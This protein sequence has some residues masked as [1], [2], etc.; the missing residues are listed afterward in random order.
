M[1]TRWLLCLLLGG[2]AYGQAPA[3][4]MSHPHPMPAQN[5][6]ADA[7]AKA[8]AAKISPGEPVITVKG[9][10]ADPAKK[11][12]T[13]ETVVTREQFERLADA[14]QPNMA[15]PIKLR[16][17]NGYSR[18]I[19]LS[20][21]AEK[22]GLD[23][24][25][26]FEA[27]MNFARM[28]ILSQQLTSSLQEESQKVS[29][30]DIEK[31]YND[32]IDTYQEATLQRLYVPH[33]KQVTPPKAAPGVKKDKEAEE[34]E[35]QARIKAGEE[36]MEKTADALRARAAKGESFDALE[37]EAYLAAGLKGNPPSTKM[38]KIRPTSLPPT[39][40][41]ALELKPGD[42]SEVIADPT[43]FYIYKMV[44]KQ[45]LPLDT[46]KPEIKNWIASQR[47]RDAMQEFQGTS[48]LNNA[49]FGITPKPPAKP[50]SEPDADVD[51]D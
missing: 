9:A 8:A 30:A 49:Y 40:H 46:V 18:L 23:K 36:A 20:Q 12:E 13:C 7:D 14:L 25:P 3:P 43:G 48:D 4:P 50:G 39:H 19:G 34:K 16:L 15:P 38:E 41:A 1:R 21:E 45:I 29:D 31:Y 10:C 27:N 32:K 5:A 44:S 37:K 28:Q 42:V 17:A 11:G 51:P 24:T 26:K 2:L 22:R 47:F 33:T 35:E 6:D